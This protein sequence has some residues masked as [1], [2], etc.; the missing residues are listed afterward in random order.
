MINYSLISYSLAVFEAFR[1]RS[2]ELFI[3]VKALQKTVR[4]GMVAD[5]EVAQTATADAVAETPSPENDSEEEEAEEAL[6]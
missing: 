6:L 4:S 3:A 2:D 1:Q 5:F